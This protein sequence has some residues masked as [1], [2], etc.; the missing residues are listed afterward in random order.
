LD[1]LARR[2][3]LL[4]AASEGDNAASTRAKRQ[5]GG[6]R[7]PWDAGMRASTALTYHSSATAHLRRRQMLALGSAARGL[8]HAVGSWNDA[9]YIL[10]KR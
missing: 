2:R 3:A 7:W 9:G 8:E 6:A 1:V 4:W 10:L 5:A